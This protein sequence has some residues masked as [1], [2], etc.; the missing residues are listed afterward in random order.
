MEYRRFGKTELLISEIGYGAWGIGGAMWQGSKDADSIQAL[1]RAFDLGVNFVDTAL[2]YGDGHSESLVGGVLKKRSE[3]IY[4]ASKI[5]PKN[6][7]WPA[8]LG[9]PL[10]DAFPYDYII[11]ST[12]TSLSNLRTDTIDIQQF[13]VWDD[14][15]ATEKE[16][17]DA[18]AKLKEDGKIRF[19]GVSINDHQP[20]NALKLAETGLVD[21]IQVIYN[22]FDQSPEK[23]LFPLCQK[24][25]IGVIVRVPL[26][27]GGLTGK[28]NPQ[29]IFPEGDF[30]NRY[31]RDDRKQQIFERT[32]KLKNLLGD[33]INTLSELALRFCLQHLAVSTVIPGMRTVANVE[34]NCKV[35]DGVKL[36]E[37]MMTELKKHAWERNFYR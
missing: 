17:Q 26:D 21:S 9:T 32:E 18:I 22:I 13:H 3:K 34:A 29:S 30:R 35:S 25:D 4:V 8:R 36:S 33:E 2:I 5:P 24:M 7:K 27:E 6:G 10:R 37:F 19:F 14:S 16:W 1:Y 23:N 15:W 12:E 11:K 28:I 31:F 20:D